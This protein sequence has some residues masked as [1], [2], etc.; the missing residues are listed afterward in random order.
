M[1][2]WSTQNDLAREIAKMDMVT[3]TERASGFKELDAA[4]S[5]HAASIIVKMY[6]THGVGYIQSGRYTDD[7]AHRTQADPYRTRGLTYNE[8]ERVKEITDKLFK[9]HWFPLSRIRKN[10]CRIASKNSI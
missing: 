4:K 7:I 9:W 10:M 2:R 6:K 8:K 3:Q 5:S 1:N